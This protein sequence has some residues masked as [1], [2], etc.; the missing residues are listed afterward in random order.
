MAQAIA[1]DAN[2]AKAE[3]LSVR[4]EGYDGPA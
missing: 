4:M 2:R 1:P 3:A